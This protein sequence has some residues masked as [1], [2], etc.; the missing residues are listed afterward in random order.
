[1]LVRDGKIMS[2]LIISVPTSFMDTT[3]IIAVI[4]AKKKLYISVLIPQLLAKASSKHIAK[5]LL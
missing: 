4:S 2:A 1:M 3:T 5:I